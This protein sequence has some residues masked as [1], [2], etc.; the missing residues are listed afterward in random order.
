MQ[1]SRDECTLIVAHT[2][3]TIS[4]ATPQHVKC[5]LTQTVHATRNVGGAG[6]CIAK[7]GDVQVLISLNIQLLFVVDLI[8]YSN[9]PIGL[10]CF[11]SMYV[12]RKILLTENG[13]DRSEAE[14]CTIKIWT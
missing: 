3:L 10:R 12:I 14:R 8:C 4:Y 1:S 13:V 5:V 6:V 2:A 9:H 7:G 11:K